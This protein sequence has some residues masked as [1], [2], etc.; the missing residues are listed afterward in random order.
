MT[1]QTERYSREELCARIGAHR[2]P[3]WQELPELELYMD[4]VLSLI[5]RYLGGYP[6]FD[7]RGLTAAMVNNYVKQGVLP[8]PKKKRYSRAHLAQLLIICLLKTSLPISDI[9]SLTEGED[10]EGFYQRF[11]ALFAEVNRETAELC[12]AAEEDPAASACRAALRAQ[13][14]QALAAGLCGGEVKKEDG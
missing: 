1:E 3:A 11:A 12:L 9:R 13:A 5:A 10:T 6:G 2:L 4:Q 7:K 14:E 8:A